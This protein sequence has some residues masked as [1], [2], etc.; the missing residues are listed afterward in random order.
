MLNLCTDDDDVDDDGADAD[1]AGDDD[2]V[3][4]YRLTLLAARRAHARATVEAT[5]SFPIRASRQATG[6][7]GMGWDGM[8]RTCRGRASIP[9]V[10]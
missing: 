7:D 5:P 4:S 8:G 1:D 10:I 9:L 2:A 6:W 3:L